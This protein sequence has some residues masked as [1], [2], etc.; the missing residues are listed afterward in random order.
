MSALI[1]GR[2]EWSYSDQ[3][4]A[5]FFDGEGCVS[6]SRRQRTKSFVEHYLSVQVGQIIRAPLEA[7]R[8]HNGGNIYQGTTQS[9]CWR[10]KI[11]GKPAERFLKSIYQFS[12]VKRHEISLALSLRALIGE[13]GKRVS[14]DV[15][16]EKEKIYLDF[17]K[18]RDGLDL[19]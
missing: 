15:F 12:I 19:S 6:I 14:S 10:W 18:L 8:Q 13:P 2:R 7:L 4:A 9:R 11:H 16:A 5:G 3:W 1:I 17:R